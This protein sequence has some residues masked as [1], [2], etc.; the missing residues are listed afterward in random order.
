MPYSGGL[1]RNI[2]QC[3][4]DFDIPLMLSH[5]VTEIHGS[6][7]I[8]GVTISKVDNKMK[9]VP[10]TEQYIPCDTLL[11]SVGLIPENELSK[12]AG[13]ELS[14]ITKGAVV[15]QNR[16]TSAEGIFACGNV[17]HVHD[18]ADF[19][20]EEAEIAGEKAAQF[21]NSGLTK[22]G[23]I[24]IKTDG[25]VRYTVPQRITDRNLDVKVFFRVADV[26][27]NAKISVISG[28]KIIATKKQAKV[29]PGEMQTIIIKSDKLKEVS[30][31][32]KIV[33]D[34]E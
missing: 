28:D 23:N 18:L 14:G 20:S 22:D 25:K 21:I 29:A 24:E 12:T 34:H 8:T 6:E 16:Q 5:T 27:R 1:E 7:R 10:G 15:D 3:L 9:P 4:R 31:E 30:Q 13:I 11:L 26:Y 33:L 32:I 2:Q 19:V 17:L